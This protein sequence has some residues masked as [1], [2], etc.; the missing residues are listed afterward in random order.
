MK[1]NCNRRDGNSDQIEVLTVDEYEPDFRRVNF[2]KKSK[3]EYAEI[4]GTF[5]I[6]TTSITT[7]LDD[8]RERPVSAFMYVWSACING[9]E[10]YG[11]TWEDFLSLLCKLKKSLSLDDKRFFVLYVHNLP[12]EFSFLQGYISDYSGLFAT[13]ERKPLVWRVAEYGIEFRCSYKL[14]NMSLEK[15]TEK[16]AGC[17][18][19]KA[20]GDLDYK[21]IRTNR[22]YIEP[23]EWGYIINDTLG[24]WEALKYKLAADGDTITT[25]PLT[26][27]GYVRRD[28][29]RATSR[30]KSFSIL[31]KK[32]AL[33]NEMYTELREA[34]RGGDTHANKFKCNR[35]IKD[36]F[37]FD[38]SSMYPA[39]LL[40][41]KYPM[42]AFTKV[43]N[44]NESIFELLDG[45][46]WFARVRLLN[47]RMK[48]GQ[49]NPYLSISKC[50]EIE[51]LDNDNGRVWEADSLY[52]TITDID[53]EILLVCY[54]FDMEFIDGTLYYAYYGYLPKIFTDVIMA[55][56]KAKTELKAETKRLAEGTKELE[57]AE[58]N[59][60]K[61]KNKLNG[62]YGM[63]ATDPVRETTVYINGEWEVFDF[64]RYKHDD[65]YKAKIDAL[66]IDIPEEKTIEELTEKAVLP[67][68]W[69]VWTT[70]HA[71]M[72]LR[73]LIDIAGS[74][75]IYCDTDSVKSSGFDFERLK[76][77]N[78]WIYKL[79]EER[80]AYID[81]DGK[82][83]YMGFFDNESRLEED[84]IAPEYAAFKTLGAKKYCFDKYGATRGE[85][86]FGCTIS[87]VRK[88]NGAKAIKNLDNF[89]VGFKIR[90]SGGFNVAYYDG[91]TVTK[92]RITDYRG[93]TS[94]VEYTGYSCMMHREYEIG[95]TE[96]QALDYQVIDNMIE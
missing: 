81:V 6:E 82:R 42:T 38:A 2:L 88:S 47:I 85:T 29:K 11:R 55:Y 63:A 14:T 77:L 27:T 94:E 64:R 34:F 53:Y 44:I 26:S 28:V 1:V 7:T 54:D 24:L 25:V 89:K 95:I 15:F 75:Y 35:I 71:R 43:Q 32:L 18:H 23:A 20:S 60:M 4:F 8:G 36:V 92:E 31:K 87:G 17:I 68:Q 21:L 57:E 49:Y 69:G 46:A 51:N 83:A 16:T 56:F 61:S 76:K 13:G 66:G 91:Q 50:A 37:S 90:D 72:H 86:F 62:I 84:G 12:F 48:Q 79:C 80:G 22:T 3:T 65:A 67:Y 30:G 45:K 5:D 96:K 58:Y 59:L 78:E 19:T 33:N 52:T 41:M 73:R 93:I 70:A 9:T 40:L 39:M 74:D 10:V